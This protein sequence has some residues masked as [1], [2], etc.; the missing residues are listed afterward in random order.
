MFNVY[1]SMVVLLNFCGYPSLRIVTREYGRDRT[2]PPPHSLPGKEKKT[3]CVEG[4]NTRHLVADEG[5]DFVEYNNSYIDAR[6]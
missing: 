1:G 2:A 5:R 4:F 6:D 3:F